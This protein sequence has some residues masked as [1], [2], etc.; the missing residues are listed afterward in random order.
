MFNMKEFINRTF[1]LTLTNGTVLNVYAP[2]VKYRYEISN[3]ISKIEN[4]S[5]LDNL[6]SAVLKI[7]NFNLEKEEIEEMCTEDML[8]SFIN[9]YS[10]WLIGVVDEKN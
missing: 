1:E 2:K 3:L 4:E 7:I 9:S 10:N 5:S 6:I 8:I